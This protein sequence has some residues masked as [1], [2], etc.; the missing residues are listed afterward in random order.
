MPFYSSESQR[1]RPSRGVRSILTDPYFSESQRL[2]CS[3]AMHGSHAMH[4]ILGS[5][6][7]YAVAPRPVADVRPSLRPM[8]RSPHTMHQFQRN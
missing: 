4:S 3:R 8:T 7:G 2:R 5:V 1:L 6:N